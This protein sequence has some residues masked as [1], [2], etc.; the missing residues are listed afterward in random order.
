VDGLQ[1]TVRHGAGSSGQGWLRPVDTPDPLPVL[2]TG[3]LPSH[4]TGLDGQPV[5]VSAAGTVAGLPRLGGH[6]ALLDLEYADRLAD[7]TGIALDPQVWLGADAPAD[8]VDRL[9]AQ[10]LVVTRDEQLAA[11]QARLDGQG[12]ALALRFWLVCAGLGVLLAAGAIGLVASVDRRRTG[13]DV[14]ALRT[15][16][17]RLPTVPGYVVVVALAGIVGLGAAA[18][19]WSLTGA[20][21]P[22][23]VDGTAWPVPAWPRPVAVLLPCL[24]AALV[25]I[26]VAIVAAR[27][28]TGRYRP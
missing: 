23:F 20:D 1:W 3:P 15:Q 12:P 21:V 16:G 19:A 17:V 2:G 9:T 22:V 11:V 8:V 13:A 28:R 27:P 10:G 5:P 14:A 26:G 24:A 7:D 6:G 25:L 18:L 4:L